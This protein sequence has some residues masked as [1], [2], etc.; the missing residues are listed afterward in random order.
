M[1]IMRINFQQFIDKRPIVDHR[2]PHF[3]RAGFA[4]VPPQRERA[5]GTVILNDHW[6][7]DGHVVGTAIEVFE[8]VATRGHHLSHE[9]IGFAHGAVR[10]V[11]EARLDAAPL[12]GERVGL[13]VSELVQLETADALGALSQNGVRP[14]GTDSLN[15]S[16]ILGPEAFAQVDALSPACVRPDRK[17]EQQH[18]NSNPDDHEGL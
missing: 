15:G 18:D 17:R 10:V 16:L 13:F 14:L 12:A 2:L 4:A 8:R 7:V 11:H 3:F 6:M 1:R 5:G 9:L